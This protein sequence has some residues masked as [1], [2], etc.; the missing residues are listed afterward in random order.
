MSL[1]VDPAVSHVLL[2]GLNEH[3]L[4]AGLGELDAVFQAPSV[5]FFNGAGRG[6]VKV[7][8]VGVLEGHVPGVAIGGS[9]LR[10]RDLIVLQKHRA[11]S[12]RPRRVLLLFPRLQIGGALQG[13]QPEDALQLLGRHVHL[14]RLFGDV[15]L[16]AID[17]LQSWSQL[18]RH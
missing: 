14:L 11:S 2:N 1:N 4:A 13:I 7:E 15:G 18:I 3:V 12:P 6:P 5:Q 16:A 8:A 9:D 10:L 17:P